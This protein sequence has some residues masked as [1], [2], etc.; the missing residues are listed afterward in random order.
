LLISGA[1]AGDW[2]GFLPLITIRVQIYTIQD[3]MNTSLAL[4]DIIKN[5]VKLQFWEDFHDTQRNSIH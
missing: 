5:N 4:R 3:K 1:F 2:Q